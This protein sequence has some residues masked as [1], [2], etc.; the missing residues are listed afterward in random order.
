MSGA[1]AGL[2]LALCFA[3]D[4]YGTHQMLKSG[5]REVMIQQPAIRLSLKAAVIPLYLHEQKKSKLIRFGVPVVFAA[6]GAWNLRVAHVQRGRN[7]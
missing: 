6:A 3:A 5:G 2:F 7:R 1:E 4:E